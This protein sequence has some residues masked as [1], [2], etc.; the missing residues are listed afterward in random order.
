MGIQ[1]LEPVGDDLLRVQL[2]EGWSLQMA[3]RDSITGFLHRVSYIMMITGSAQPKHFL[4]GRRGGPYINL[5]K[6]FDIAVRNEG[7]PGEFREKLSLIFSDKVNGKG[8]QVGALKIFSESYYKDSLG[9]TFSDLRGD[10]VGAERAKILERV[11]TVKD[12][13]RTDA[14]TILQQAFPDCKDGT[15]YWDEEDLEPQKAQLQEKL[16][17]FFERMKTIEGPWVVPDSSVS[18]KAASKVMSFL[19]KPSP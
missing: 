18:A 7:V 10:A 6:R 11:K 12:S 16:E 14:H 9:N 1:I 5:T 17:T 19:G 15:A 4:T 8:F 3:T 2:P 13:L